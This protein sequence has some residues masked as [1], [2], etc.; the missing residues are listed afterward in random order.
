MIHIKTVIFIAIM[1]FLLYKSF[2][3]YSEGNDY[4][5]LSFMTNLFWIFITVLFL[6]LYAGI[7]W[8]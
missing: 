1:S 6:I 4:F 3:N 8:W 2:K 5:G 7:F